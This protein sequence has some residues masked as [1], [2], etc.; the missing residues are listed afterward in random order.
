MSNLKGAPLRYIHKH[1]QRA[2]LQSAR[3]GTN[4]GFSFKVGANSKDLHCSTA[5]P[6]RDCWPF[7]CCSSSRVAVKL[8]LSALQK[9]KLWKAKKRIFLISSP[10]PPPKKAFYRLIS[11]GNFPR[12]PVSGD[13]HLAPEPRCTSAHRTNETPELGD[14][15]IAK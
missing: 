14:R 11:S 13:Y 8:L 4:K 1:H 3:H 7:C 6:F 12:R 9:H 10:P 5:K 2:S 15:Q